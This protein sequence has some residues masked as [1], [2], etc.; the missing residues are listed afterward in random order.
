MK[1]GC[2]THEA[3][4]VD[5]CLCTCGDRPATLIVRWIEHGIHGHDGRYASR[6]AVKY[7]A[8]DT[9]SDWV[10]RYRHPTDRR[11]CNEVVSVS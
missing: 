3:G 9:A 11:D 10:G 1:M 5:H 8:D 6:Y 7:D 2:C 4:R